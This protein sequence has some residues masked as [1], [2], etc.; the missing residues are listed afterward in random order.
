MRHKPERAL[1]LDVRRYSSFNTR[2]VEMRHKPERALTHPDMYVNGLTFYVE[3]RHK[4]ERAL[5]PANA[6][7]T[8]RQLL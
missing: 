3:M 7:I 2:S 8:S 4:P 5:T 1:T 6:Y